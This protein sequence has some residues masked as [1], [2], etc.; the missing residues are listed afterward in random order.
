M[1][2]AGPWIPS[3]PKVIT[4]GI[5]CLTNEATLICGFGAGIVRIMVPGQTKI[6]V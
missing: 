3:N 2:P 6:L 1:V 4:G 5:P